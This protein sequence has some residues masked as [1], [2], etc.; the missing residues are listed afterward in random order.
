MHVTF[1]AEADAVYIYFAKPN[2]VKVC[3]TT[4]LAHN[5]IADYDSLDKLIGIEILNAQSLIGAPESV[6]N[7]IFQDLW[8]E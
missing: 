1:D 7:L 3:Y 5:I 8:E 4:E 2:T 6:K